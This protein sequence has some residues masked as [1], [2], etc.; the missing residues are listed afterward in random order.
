MA[1]GLNTVPG[2]NYSTS[3]S[4]CIT[5][6]RL[7]LKLVQPPLQICLQY[8]TSVELSTVLEQQYKRQHYLESI[9]ACHDVV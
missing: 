3:K 2:P 1:P 4:M 8:S 7:K 5:V 9:T 6:V